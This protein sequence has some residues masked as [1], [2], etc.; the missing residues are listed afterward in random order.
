MSSNLWFNVR[1]ISQKDVCGTRTSCMTYIGPIGQECL[2]CK[3]QAGSAGDR[4]RIRIP[5]TVSRCDLA[6]YYEQLYSFRSVYVHNMDTEKLTDVVRQRPQ[7]YES[8]NKS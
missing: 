7:L 6:D 8:N 3:L 1:H 4:R 2:I 5:A